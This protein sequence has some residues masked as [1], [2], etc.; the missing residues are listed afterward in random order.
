LLFAFFKS[1]IRNE[2]GGPVEGRP[3]GIGYI[4]DDHLGMEGKEGRQG[5]TGGDK[6]GQITA[7]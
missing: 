2:E 1:K 3:V 4:E 7:V 5:A 6:N